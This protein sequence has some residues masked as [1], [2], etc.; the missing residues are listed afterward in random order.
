MSTLRKRVL[1]KKEKSIEENTE[2]LVSQCVGNNSKSLVR[3][4]QQV[5][6]VVQWCAWCSV[7]ASDEE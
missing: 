5:N 3:I 4:H 1:Q 2:G 6:G 7:Q